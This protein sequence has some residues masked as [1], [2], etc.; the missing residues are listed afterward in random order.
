KLDLSPGAYVGDDLTTQ[1]IQQ[2]LAQ[3]GVKVDLNP[4]EWSAWVKAVGSG[5]Y[6]TSFVGYSSGDNSN[7]QILSYF[8]TGFVQNHANDPKYDELVKQIDVA[9]TSADQIAATKKAVEESYAFAQMIWLF[10]Q[11]QTF[12]YAADLT[13]VPR[14]DDWLR[15]QDVH[16]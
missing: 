11:P 12:A 6:Q 3:I 10:P 8:V 15:P 1:A 2:Q 7:Y 5:D 16:L 9:T 14:P 4:L 13:W